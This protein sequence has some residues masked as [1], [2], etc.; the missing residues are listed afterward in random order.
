MSTKCQFKEM[1]DPN[2]LNPN[3]DNEN[4]HS[5]EQIE[6]LAKILEYQGIRKP[7]IVSNQTGFIV[8]GHATREAAILAGIKQVPV[9]YQD[10][11]G[12]QETAHRIADNAMANWA[13]IDLAQV[14][15]RLPD[16][17]PSF[18][19]EFF[20]LEKTFHVEP[21]ENGQPKE[22]TPCP[23]CGYVKAKSSE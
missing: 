16:L 15:L 2:N 17:D 10:F 9:D 8:T 18:D 20:G 3:P 4:V 6:R 21:S 14:N 12:D 5:R 1:A 19:F 11:D 22:P 7:I 23:N 13:R